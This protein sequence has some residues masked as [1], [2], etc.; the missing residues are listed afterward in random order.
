MPKATLNINDFSGGIVTNK[1][2]R[3]IQVNEAQESNGFVNNNPG[4]LKLSSGFVRAH[5]FENNEGGYEQELLSQGM[6]NS[7]AVQPEYGFR[8][9]IMVKFISSS[10]GYTTVEC[11]GLSSFTS[12]D[13]SGLQI[14]NH[15]LTTGLRAV[16]VRPS[17]SSTN[18]SCRITKVSDTQFKVKDSFDI[19]VDA[20][21]DFALLAIEASYDSS[22]I[23]GSNFAPAQTS[24]SNNNYIIKTYNQGIFGFYNVGLFGA[25]FYGEID[26]NAYPGPHGED[27][28]LFDT[29]YLWD[30]Q[31]KGGSASVPFSTTPVVDAFYDNGHFRVL[32]K[33][34]EK[35]KFGHCRRPVSYIH[36]NDKVYFSNDVTEVQLANYASSA[37][38][39]VGSLRITEGWYPLR[40]HILSPIEYKVESNSGDPEYDANYGD[41]AEAFTNS[42]T[43]PLN[44]YSGRD[45]AAGFLASQPADAS[46]LEF[47]GGRGDKR[48]G[49]ALPHR[50]VVAI[51][52]GAGDEQVEG[53]WQFKTGE[54]KKIAL[55]IS[56]VYDDIEFTRQLESTIN[57]LEA[58]FHENTIDSN[59]RWEFGVNESDSSASLQYWVYADGTDNNDSV[60]ADNTALNISVV[61]NKGAPNSLPLEEP[62]IDDCG[63]MPDTGLVGSWAVGE[64]RGSGYN[65]GNS[66][67][68][69]MNPRIVGLNV[70]LTGTDGETLE[71]PFWLATFDF[72]HNKKAVSHDG[73]EGDGWNRVSPDSDAVANN[74]FGQT[75]TGIKKI[76]NVTYKV[77]NGYSHKTVT[78][79][80][81]TTSA[82]VNRRLYA[83][84]VSY[85]DFPIEKIRDVS[86]NKK[87]THK[88]DRILVSPVNKFDILPITNFLDVVTED[89]Q[90]IVKLIGFGQKLL[91]YKNNDLFVVDASGEFEFLENTFKGMGVE[92]PARVTQTPDFIFWLNKRGIYAYGKDGTVLDI[93]KETMGVEKWKNHFSPSSHISYDPEEGQ[94]IVHCKD[95][96]EQQKDKRVI[97]LNVENGSIFF[98]RTPCIDLID[99]FSPGLII[100]NKLF[101]TGS[102]SNNTHED[103]TIYQNDGYVT[104]GSSE[105]GAKFKLG[106]A[107]GAALNAIGDNL[108]YLL[109]RK[110]SAWVVINT[111]IL[112][113]L[114]TQQDS[115]K[116]AKQTLKELNR[117]LSVND[118]YD[119]VVDY[120]HDSQYFNMKA[121][122]RISGAAYNGTAT[123]LSA[124]SGAEFG[125]SALFAF[126]ST[127]ATDGGGI[128]DSNVTNWSNSG[129]DTGVTSD[130]CVFH[131][132]ANRNSETSKGVMYTTKV[133]LKKKTADPSEGITTLTSTYVVG[134][135]GKYEKNR[136]GTGFNY[137]DD[138]GG[139]NAAN[140]ENLV[141]NLREFL[142]SNPM[143]DQFGKEVFLD[144]FFTI[145]AT[146]GSGVNETFSLT[147]LSEATEDFDEIIVDSETYNSS[148]GKISVWSNVS[149]NILTDAQ[150]VSKDFDF[151][152]P[153]VRKK[154]YRGY[155]TY[156]GDAGIKIY[157]KV[158]Q[159]GSW[160]SCTIKDDANNQLDQSTQFTREEFNFTS[161]TTSSIF[162][163]AIKLESTSLIKDFSVND[164][165]LVYRT[166]SIR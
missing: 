109:L 128:N 78:Q 152:Q 163:I 141:I 43:A 15:G 16:K 68:L 106:N 162:S 11:V 41:V 103:F 158:N 66:N 131:V 47:F 136:I 57:P 31:Q 111:E 135:H 37:V 91:I 14:I 71:D 2:P 142:V 42:G 23:A 117:K 10:G 25:G 129:M 144:E 55:G 157:Y 34:G 72:E 165:T 88:P 119:V 38:T 115:L 113:G 27:P 122:A 81:Y 96:N 3:D 33:P 155:I 69:V 159:A 130:T 17:A 79:A 65:S 151:G 164:I 94:L 101:I 82:V 18:V 85:F 139:A 138:N 89:G 56:Y 160:T 26:R 124:G 126:S 104:R 127:N 73:I 84:N 149:N 13:N 74:V 58:G 21:K 32:L 148:G 51:G 110:G 80:W 83:G 61:A 120:D 146:S 99:Y 112:S 95:V 63:L 97:L 7:W 114:G 102:N 30:W 24:P 154:V 46:S 98:K 150:W 86:E 59:G 5:G 123:D 64:Q 6:I 90:D 62:Q 93:I 87:I 35:W 161:G 67:R 36:F 153:N 156:K 22:G 75:I 60:V 1:N 49:P 54:H 116:T 108:N 132:L 53:D 20:A 166:K 125:S 147:P 133:T 44:T 145:S 45:A 8:K 121:R 4:E 48:Y 140:T 100:N 52:T 29:Q 92:N 70:W 105:G 9:F 50:Y 12:N 28:W 118:E 77:K 19:T 107:D 143:Q 134:E 39:D 137:G 40:S 76:P